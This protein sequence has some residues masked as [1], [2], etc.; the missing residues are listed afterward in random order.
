MLVI[1]SE[2]C[3]HRP[4]SIAGCG[5]HPDVLKGTIA[6]DLAIGDAIERDA[7]SKAEIIHFICRREA[8]RNTQH[9][10]FRDPLHGCGKIHITLGKGRT[11]VARRA[12]EK[13]V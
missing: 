5:L 3:A 13:V 9:D 12:T 2:G 1:S 4:A 6:Q 8:A 11:W 7:T 10:L